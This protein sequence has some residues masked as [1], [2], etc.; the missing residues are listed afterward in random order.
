MDVISPWVPASFTKPSLCLFPAKFERLLTTPYLSPTEHMLRWTGA[1]RAR[2]CT[3]PLFDNEDVPASIHHVQDFANVA[4]QSANGSSQQED[5][6]MEG[7]GLNLVHPFHPAIATSFL[8]YPSVGAASPTHPYTPAPASLLIRLPTVSALA[9]T[10]ALLA[11]QVEQRR[12]DKLRDGYAHPKQTLPPSN[13]KSCKVSPVERATGDT[14]Y[15]E[16]VKE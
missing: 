14:R 11:M 15:L 4:Q 2:E 16:A 10:T 3:S 1:Q 13:Q 6:Y 5:S 7:S 8:A 12:C 9:R